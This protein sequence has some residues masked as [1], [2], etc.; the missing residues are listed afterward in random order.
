M[1]QKEPFSLKDHLFNPSSVTRLAGW[2]KGAYPAFKE[3]VFVH[4]V[5]KEFPRLELKQRIS[6]IS[7]QLK[8]HLPSDYTQ[9]VRILVNALPPELDSEKTDNDF[10]DFVLAPFSEFVAKNGC[11]EKYYNISIGALEE[12]TKRFSAEDGIRYFINAFPDR[13]L[14]VM[15]E[16]A[17][18]P[19]YHQRRLAS[20]GSRLRLPWSQKICWAPADILPILDQLYTDST[21]Y[22]TRS[23]ANSLNDISKINPEL[24][25]R[26]I[27]KWQKSR[28]QSAK[29]MEFITRHAL[30]TLLKKGHA[31]AL[32]MLGYTP[33]SHVKVSHLFVDKQVNLGGS[34]SFSFTLSGSDVHLGKLR[35]E[36]AVYYQ[37][38]NGSQSPKV[39]KLAEAEF[40]EKKKSFSKKHSFKPMTTRR[41][42]AGEH[43]LAVL[44]NGQ[45]MERQE[46]VLI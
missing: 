7:D 3:K 30:R 11:Q 31:G 44:V 27:E 43:G 19:H 15:K 14:K 26:I 37:K 21:R 10:G 41:H 40:A 42:H 22:V 32:E 34:L 13:T 24:A 35:V 5:L 18:S 25:L 17:Q 33:A 38:A 8:A 29:E 9:A 20:E 1:P 36:Y 12:I 16:L 6:H 45:E 23:V 4:G 28:Q 39:F 46:F 2:V